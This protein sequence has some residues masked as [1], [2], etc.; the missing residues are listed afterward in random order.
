MCFLCLGG[1]Q[2]AYKKVAGNKYFCQDNGQPVVT[3]MRTTAR[4][5]QKTPGQATLDQALREGDAILQERAECPGKK[6]EIPPWLADRFKKEQQATFLNKRDA[7]GA[8]EILKS[9]DRLVEFRSLVF[10]GAPKKPLVAIRPTAV[11]STQRD[12][13]IGDYLFWMRMREHPEFEK[14]IGRAVSDIN[15][16]RE[17]MTQKGRASFDYRLKKIFEKKGHNRKQFFIHFPVMAP[18]QA[19][20]LPGP[21]PGVK[22]RKSSYDKRPGE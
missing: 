10:A 1:F 13:A 11:N 18:S 6:S 7:A 5:H 2:A 17:R 21:R 19:P 22:P 3:S 16:F 4:K 9:M 12:E 14:R 8:Q 15:H 20:I